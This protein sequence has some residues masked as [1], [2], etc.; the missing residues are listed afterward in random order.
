MGELTLLIGASVNASRVK[1][2]K[3]TSRAI[4]HNGGGGKADAAMLRAFSGVD[5]YARN[6]SIAGPTT[7]GRNTYHTLVPRAARIFSLH[8]H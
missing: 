1:T 7:V 6:I 3:I 8:F 5:N 2:V 4:R